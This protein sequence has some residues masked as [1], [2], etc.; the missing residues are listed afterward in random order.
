M[1]IALHLTGWICDWL[2]GLTQDLLKRLGKKG[3]VDG[4]VEEGTQKKG[5]KVRA[6]SDACKAPVHQTSALFTLFLLDV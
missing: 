1:S 2:Q 6:S 4:D 5:K 3:H